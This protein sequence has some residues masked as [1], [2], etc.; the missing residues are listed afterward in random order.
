MFPS[1]NIPGAT[2]VAHSCG[3]RN[4][5]LVTILR[6]IATLFTAFNHW[7]LDI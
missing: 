6:R 3:H 1:R 4:A 5:T 7:D 2:A